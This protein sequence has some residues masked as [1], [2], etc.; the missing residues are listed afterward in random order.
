M[1][2]YIYKKIGKNEKHGRYVLPI[3]VRNRD[4]L[5]KYLFSRG[6]E[7]KIFNEPLVSDAPIYKKIS[8]GKFSQAKYLL[9]KR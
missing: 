6:I 7:T 9:E 4:K 3:I 1:K 2:L 5:Q 8:K